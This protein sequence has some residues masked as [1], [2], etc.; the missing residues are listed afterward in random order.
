MNRI[1]LIFFLLS[2]CSYNQPK[3]FNILSDKNFSD[4][5]S[6]EEFRIQLDEYATNSPYPNIDN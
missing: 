2:G 1:I 3:N 6:F 4:N 5:L